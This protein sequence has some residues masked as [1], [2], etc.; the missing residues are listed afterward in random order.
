MLLKEYRICMP[1]TVAEYRIAQLYMIQK[2]SREESTGRGSGVEILKNEPYENGP[3]GKGQ[4]T[5]KIYHVGSHLP[6]WLRNILP[7]SALRVEEEAWNAYPYTRTIYK[8]PFVEKLVLDVETYFFDD[9]GEQ[10]DV[11][12]L[13]PDERKARIID[14]IDIVKDPITGSDYRP[15]EDP[16]I[17]VSEATGRGPLPPNW[18]EEFIHAQQATHETYEKPPTRTHDN[19]PAIVENL[20]PLHKRIMCAYKLCRVEFRYWGTQTRVEQFIHDTALRKTMLRAH[21]QVWAWQNEWYGLTIEEIRRL[22]E[23]TAQA[24][25]SKMADSNQPPNNDG[26]LSKQVQSTTSNINETMNA[27]EVKCNQSDEKCEF[28]SS[29][30][31]SEKFH[32]P[33]NSTDIAEQ[34][35]WA[36]FKKLEANNFELDDFEPF[37]AP[38]AESDDDTRSFVTCCSDL[39][40]NTDYATP[41]ASNF[42]SF[43]IPGIKSCFNQKPASSIQQNCG[44]LV[45]ILVI[46]GGCILDS[47]YDLTTKRSDILTFRKTIETV[48]ANHYPTLHNRIAVK[49]VPC[50][51]EIGDIFRL[52]SKLK[53]SPDPTRPIETQLLRD[54][55]PLG[56]IPLF[57]INS[58]GYSRMLEQLA[59]N[60][61]THYAEFLRSPEGIHF[62]GKVCIVADSVGSILAH[63]LLTKPSTNHESVSN[64]NDTSV[65]DIGLMRRKQFGIHSLIQLDK[66]IKTPTL[67]N[68]P[69]EVTLCPPESNTSLGNVELSNLENEESKSHSRMSSLDFQVQNFFMLG[70]PI[71]LILAY[72]YQQ[73]QLTSSIVS[74]SKTNQLI[75][76]SS[77]NMVYHL[78]K[79][80]KLSVGQA[81]NLFHL[82]DPCGFRI[83][84]LLDN[85]FSCI[86]PIFIPQ[87][88]R[89]PLG[90]GQSTN[91]IETLIQ[92]AELFSANV[93]EKSYNLSDS[94]NSTINEN[95]D[96]TVNVKRQL[97]NQQLNWEKKSIVALE[98]LKKVQQ[99]WWGPKRV[100]Y[101]VHCPEA[102]Q[103]IL[104]RARPSILHASYWESK[105]VA[106]FI[107]RQIL[108]TLGLSVL[109]TSYSAD[110]SDEIAVTEL[111]KLSLNPNQIKSQTYEV[112]DDSSIQ[113]SQQSEK[114]SSSQ[115]RFS[116]LSHTLSFGPR[117]FLKR[118]S[119][120]RLKNFKANHRANDVITT[121]GSTP[122][123][124]GRFAF[125]GLD[126]MSFSSE[127]IRVEIQSI[128][129]SWSYVCTEV[130]DSSGRIRFSL[131]EQIH[132][133]DGLYPIKMTA[134][135]DPDHPVIITLAIVPPQT[136]V[137]VF[138]VD[139]SFAASLSLM[140]K[141]PKVH[142][143]AVDV[144]R[145]WQGLGYLLIYLSARPDMQRRRVTNWMANHNFPFGMTFFLNGLYSDPLKQKAQM[146]KTVVENANLR[147]HCGYGSG[148]DINL[149][150]SLGL[151]TQNI[152]LVGKVSRSQASNGT[153]LLQGYSS[154][155]SSLING[156]TLSRPAVGSMSIAVRCCPFDLPS[157]YP[158]SPLLM[159]SN[160]LRNNSLKFS[161]QLSQRLLFNDEIEQNTL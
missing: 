4:Y 40:G 38:C 132:L 100:D 133:P 144:A 57:L 39:T 18:R 1:L 148:K 159:E 69:S 85:R 10:D 65:T 5:F 49:L 30:A 50:P 21:R 2:K 116:N 138:S 103:N 34:N 56:S 41:L 86:S 31:T 37:T 113:I 51:T 157:V 73:N 35:L 48:T 17:Y 118:T 140:G 96:S 152:F 160:L 127:K 63:D 101:N 58:S 91:L 120:E 121:T 20:K 19:S 13:S 104:A 105:D 114:S 25:A 106:S 137:V 44:K 153:P 93:S 99:S 28:E 80:I 126:L 29:A 111:A 67:I 15:E 66:Q 45:L 22:E 7:S 75:T 94:D 98:A 146:L 151:S 42:Q 82:T 129:G 134:E 130:T 122:L 90:D 141:D 97:T 78:S 12:N 70:S 83:E 95:N 8:V 11:F 36:D 3:G 74:S 79:E 135:S 115:S 53:A 139:G 107:I 102:M 33:V 68:S 71:G 112:M 23:E 26:E 46:H 9:A 24:L 142:P 128:S 143:G 117:N 76:N 108:D 54:L 47:T 52:F 149:Y 110:L 147:V 55:M 161:P 87:Y 88:V 89:Y 123:I 77:Y 72:R 32:L 61:N 156:H 124:T 131:P 125:G 62:S 154:H 16:S 27:I 92:Q 109:E 84:P 81:Y 6:T 43:D 158:S 145:H 60:L 155:L 59:F 119:S 136:E 14:F 64:N 150:R